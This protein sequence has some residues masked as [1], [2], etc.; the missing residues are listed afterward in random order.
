M[1]L[2]GIKS[3]HLSKRE[4]RVRVLDRKGGLLGMVFGGLLVNS[5]KR[6]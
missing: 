2:S 1:M 4:M 3:K 6:F 5:A